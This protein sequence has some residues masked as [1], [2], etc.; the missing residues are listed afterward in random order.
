MLRYEEYLNKKIKNKESK[1]SSKEATKFFKKIIEELNLNNKNYEMYFCDS[2]NK[3]KAFYDSEKMRFYMYDFT[4][5]K[6]DIKIIVEYNGTKY[7]PKS[8]D[9]N[10]CNFLNCDNQEDVE[11][12]FL[13]DETKLKFVENLGY[14]T[15]Q[16][17][18]DDKD[19]YNTIKNFYMKIKSIKR[20]GENHTWDI[21]VPDGNEFLT[22]NGCVTHNSSTLFSNNESFEPFSDL[23]YTRNL[24]SGEFLICNKHLQKDFKEIG[25]WY[26]TKFLEEFKTK[27]S[28]QTIDFTK[29][30][31]VANIKGKEYFDRI[32]HLKEKYR[33]IWDISQK[34]L[35]D[36][37]SDRQIFIDQSQSM[38][39]YL[40]STNNS[41]TTGKVMSMLNYANDKGLKTL[42]YYLRS[43]AAVDMKDSS[44]HLSGFKYIKPIVRKN[45]SGQECI[46]CG[47]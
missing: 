21:N 44:T 17:W 46:G 2:N 10:Y 14:K 12:Q 11:K 4:L 37:A 8:K 30:E 20:N 3:E 22:S 7:H 42:I 33:S 45:D 24:Q 41:N 31:S 6:D 19:K 13:L 28:L 26:D 9:D 40:N 32:N 25:L 27:Q 38:N 23:V 5:I 47:S 36:M 39:L 1:Y 15:I 16:I 34:D 29:Y 43:K 35:I 18:S